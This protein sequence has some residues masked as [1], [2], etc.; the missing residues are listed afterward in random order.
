VE[1]EDQTRFVRSEA[2]TTEF[3]WGFVQGEIGAFEYVLENISM[4]DDDVL[5]IRTNMNAIQV[6]QKRSRE[7]KEKKKKT[8]V[9]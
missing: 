1:Q 8:E 6:C 2:C 3:T 4:H 7:E 9:V 5:H